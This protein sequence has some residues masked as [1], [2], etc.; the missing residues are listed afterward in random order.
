VLSKGLQPGLGNWTIA[1]PRNFQYHFECAE[2]KL[3]SFNP[4]RKYQLVAALVAKVVL[5]VKGNLTILMIILYD[6]VK[7]PTAL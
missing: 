3:Q 4:S 2:N 5:F 1:L 6:T 7:C